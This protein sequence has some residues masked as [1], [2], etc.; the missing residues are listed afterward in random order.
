MAI[1]T[2][3]K[4]RS[5]LA[6]GMQPWYPVGPLPDATTSE[7]DRMAVGWAYSGNSL[8]GAPPPEESR[9]LLLQLGG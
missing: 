4:R 2:E 9:S 6:I 5:V 1:N 7:G 3:A 8:G